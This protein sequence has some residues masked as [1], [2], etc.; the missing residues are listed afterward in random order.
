MASKYHPAVSSAT[1]SVI[2]LFCFFFCPFAGSQH[3]G[4][5]RPHRHLWCC[6][7]RRGRPREEEEA[8]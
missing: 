8:D 7:R 2:V 6:G 1:K 3:R 5:R 4:Y